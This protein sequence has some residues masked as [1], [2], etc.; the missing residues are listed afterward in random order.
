MA[1]T[2]ADT[3]TQTAKKQ[4]LYS[5]FF[6]SFTKSPF[7][8]ELAL[9]KN[10]KSVNQALKN[11]ILTNYGERFFTPNFGSNVYADIFELS[12]EDSLDDIKRQIAYSINLYEPRVNLLDV[13]VN[14]VGDPNSVE[15]TIVYSLINSTMPVTLNFILKRVR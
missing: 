3:L 10:E 15:I 11:L 4:N 2:R 14:P 12:V 7:S 6:D 5:D 1:V 8:G 13:E 9:V